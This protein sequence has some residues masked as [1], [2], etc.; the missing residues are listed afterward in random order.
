MHKV[1]RLALA[2]CLIFGHA[3]TAAEH[4]APKAEKK[5]PAK[6]PEKKKAAPPAQSAAGAE[7]KVGYSDTQIQLGGMM[8]PTL[9]R[10]GATYQVVTLRLQLAVGENER[11]ACWMAPIVAEKLLMYLH[12]AKLEA[13]D[14][15]G[16]RREL[17]VKNLFDVAV[18]ATDRG[19]YTGV[20][21]LDETTP[22]LTDPRSMTLSSQCK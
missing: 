9:G 16:Q 8:A 12:S 15:Q 5:A 14:F 18:K 4:A 10:D 19:Y 21:L 2:A 13:A 20:V 3:A 6:A 11:A 22:P 17:L 7:G 1:A